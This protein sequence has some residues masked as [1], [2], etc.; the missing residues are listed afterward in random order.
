MAQLSAHPP[1]EGIDW[2]RPRLKG[3]WLDSNNQLRS[4][5]EKRE[6][7]PEAEGAPSR[8]QAPTPPS[9][10]LYSQKLRHVLRQHKVNVGSIH[11]ALDDDHID[12]MY[13]HTNFQAADIFTKA[14]EL[15]RPIT[16]FFHQGLGPGSADY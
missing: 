11:D 9:A 3:F 14:L 15:A 6:P 10:G 7:A 1:P 2:T 4:A 12:I 5:Y 8:R 13:C 16:I